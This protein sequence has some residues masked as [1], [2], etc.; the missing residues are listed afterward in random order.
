[1]RAAREEKR[2]EAQRRAA[3]YKEAFEAKRRRMDEDEGRTTRNIAKA[4]K[5]LEEYESSEVIKVNY[6]I[7]KEDIGKEE[8]R[9][10][11]GEVTGP[12]PNTT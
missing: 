8:G 1:M 12:I 11:W 4:G 6:M 10:S 5:T 7:Q 9:P 2:Q 3:A